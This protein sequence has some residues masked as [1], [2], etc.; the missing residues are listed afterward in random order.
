M[1]NYGNSNNSQ[2]TDN[3][4]NQISLSNSNNSSYDS[5][6]NI[7]ENQNNV[8]HKQNNNKQVYSYSLLSTIISSDNKKNK[9]NNKNK[10]K[11]TK[12]NSKKRKNKKIEKNYYKN[13]YKKES[14]I[15]ICLNLLFWIWSILVIL[16]HNQII[17]FPR[18][19]SGKKI[20]IIYSGANNDSFWGG[21]LST[22]IFTIFNYIIGFLY[23]EILFIIFYCVYIAYSLINISSEIF[24][25]KCFLSYNMFIFLVFLTLGEIYKLFARKYINI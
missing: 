4:D 14:I 10:K 6:V 13:I 12:K 2:N 19:S 15:G 16:D 17:K 22:L 3:D 11:K 25:N 9:T 24:K 23:P 7:N 5:K 1:E 18:S 21:I 20:Y 8:E